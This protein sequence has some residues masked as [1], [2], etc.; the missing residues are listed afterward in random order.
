MNRPLILFSFLFCAVQAHAQPNH[1]FIKKGV[2]KKKTFSQGDM[3]HVQ[4]QNGQQKKGT[5]TMLQDSSIFI[6]GEPILAADIAM[7]LLDKKKKPFPVDAKTVFMIGAGAALTAIGLSLNGANKPGT[8][9][10]AGAVIGF[11]P[12]LIK[13]TGGKFLWML[14]R[15]K[16]R[17]GKKFRLQVFDIVPPPR[18]AF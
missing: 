7:I 9:I 10:I 5:I 11:G 15:K 6:D 4:F 1:L 17:I 8:A 3:I 12:L 16:F 13:Y 18:H 2:H 14:H